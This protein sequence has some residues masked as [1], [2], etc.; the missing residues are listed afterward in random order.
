MGFLRSKLRRRR[1][2]GTSTPPD[3]RAGKFLQRIPAG[4]TIINNQILMTQTESVASYV[5]SV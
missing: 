3:R 5:L 1:P 4:Q 2:F